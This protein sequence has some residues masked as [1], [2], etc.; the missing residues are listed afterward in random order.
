[1]LPV[2]YTANE[3]FGHLPEMSWHMKVSYH[4]RL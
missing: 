3:Y 1:M 4:R 2:T